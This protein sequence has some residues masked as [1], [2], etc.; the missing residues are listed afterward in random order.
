MNN[1]VEKQY[2]PFSNNASFPP[3]K[4]IMIDH[5]KQIDVNRYGNDDE[6]YDPFASPVSQKTTSVHP[7]SGYS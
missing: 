7:I 5:P 4:S 1:I 2:T 3:F 6:F